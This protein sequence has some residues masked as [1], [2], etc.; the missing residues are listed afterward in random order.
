VT[1]AGPVLMIGLDMG[2]G[3]LLAEWA[4]AGHLPAVAALLRDGRAQSLE[5]TAD[6]LHVS[7]WPSLY[8]GTHP[9]EHGVYYTFQPAPGHQGWLKFQGDQY[10]RP[11]F[12]SLLARAGVGCSVLDAP[13]THPEEGGATQVIDWGSWAPYWKPA[14]TPAGVLDGLRRARGRYPLGFHALDVGMERLD[15]ADMSR[16]LVPA[17]R[18]KTDAARWVMGERPWE[19]FFTVYGES[20]AAAHYCWGDEAALQAV[21][22]EI[23]RGIGALV[24][25]AGPDAA[26][27]LVSGDGVGPNRAGWH[28]LPE[29]LRRLGYL[30]EPSEAQQGQA[31]SE[32]PAGRRPLD[33]VKLLRDLL[34]KDLRKAIARKLL[35][36]ALR[37]RLAQRID[38]A[39]VDWARTRAYCLPT[40]LEGHIRVNLRGREPQGSVAPG[41]E[42]RRVLDDLTAALGALTHAGSDRPAVRAVLR[43]D[44]LYP[45][46][47]RDY[48]P[49]LIVLWTEGAPFTALASPAVGTVS[50]PSPDG[51]PGTHVPPGY[52]VRAGTGARSLGE[53]RHICDIAPELLR[54]FGVAVPD[55][56]GRAPAALPAGAG[57]ETT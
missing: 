47:R 49:D 15:P 17:A 11:T 25:Q 38:T 43:T 5:T 4:R 16:K 13:Y 50:G 14:S 10:G 54:H 51:R 44:D 41:E 46:P 7:G 39:T 3:R 31:G 48:L 55:Y 26:V 22:Q 37:H 42:Y 18:A 21:Y 56:M 36:D 32:V 29:V 52:L 12:W 24:Q 45:G 53:L 9:G 28:L 35:P 20:H 33:P 57:R 8:T 2:D 40:D 23:D 19:L 6:A 34:P 1:V 27:Y 30:A